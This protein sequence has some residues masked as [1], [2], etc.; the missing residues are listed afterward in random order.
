MAAA[1]PSVPT[2]LGFVE[3]D[4]YATS[5]VGPAAKVRATYGQGPGG[6]IVIPLFSN[7]G[8]MPFLRNVICSMRRLHVNNWLVIAM[9]NATCPTLMGTPG[10][11]EQS[12]CVYPYAHSSMAVTTN[13]NVATYRSVNFNRMV[14]QRPLWVRW[15]LQQ[16]YSVLQCDLD[17]VWLHDP[18]PVL[19]ALRL[20]G[21]KKAVVSSLQTATPG[22]SVAPTAPTVESKAP[23]W[24]SAA[25]GN[26]TF[27]DM[28]FQSEQ[29]YGLNGGFYFA[30]PSVATLAF[31]EAWVER[32]KVTTN[33]PSNPALHPPVSPLKARALLVSRAS[34]S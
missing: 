25:S 29:A 20:T 24:S 4:A 16:G 31:Y 7:A 32:L 33:V 26:K 18:Q 15:L 9:D 14:M 5:V 6:P 34:R 1:V 22:A 8:F 28:L 21:K 10:D 12:A 23:R 13:N 19:R 3:L 11:G 17:L 30:R 27:P 2:G